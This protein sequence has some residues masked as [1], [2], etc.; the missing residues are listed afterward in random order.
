MKIE[1][2]NKGLKYLKEMEFL[3]NSHKKELSELQNKKEASSE[4]T[5]DNYLSLMREKVG[6]SHRDWNDAMKER[7]KMMESKL[8]DEDS[9]NKFSDS[10][11]RSKKKEKR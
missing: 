11:E 9:S 4:V 3:R 7:E 1:N 6:I 8:G 2:S 5:V 10:D